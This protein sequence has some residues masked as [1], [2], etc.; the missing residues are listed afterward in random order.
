MAKK[1]Y[2]PLDRIPSPKAIRERL[3]KTLLLAEK[4]Q[5]L[6]E[7]AERLQLPV[8]TADRLTAA[9]KANQKGETE[10]ASMRTFT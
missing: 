3:S 2:D 6:L 8:V 9:D 7:L 1:E 5:I 10:I 4:L